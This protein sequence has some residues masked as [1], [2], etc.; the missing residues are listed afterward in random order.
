VLIVSPEHIESAESRLPG[1]FRAGRVV[2]SDG[3][4]RV[5]LRDER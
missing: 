3:G 1:S 2:T 4:E 5:I